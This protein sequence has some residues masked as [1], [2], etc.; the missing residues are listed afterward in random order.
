M[1]TQNFAGKYV[2]ISGIAGG[3]EVF[4]GKAIDEPFADQLMVEGKALTVSP[5]GYMTAKPFVTMCHFP[6]RDANCQIQQITTPEVLAECDRIHSMPVVHLN[7]SVYPMIYHWI[8][9][10]I[11]REAFPAWTQNGLTNQRNGNMPSNPFSVF[12]DGF[13][14]TAEQFHR[15][16]FQSPQVS[17]SR[18]LDRLSELKGDFIIEV[19]KAT[20]Q[21]AVKFNQAI[22]G[23]PELIRHLELIEG[24]F[25]NVPPTNM[26]ASWT[27][28]IQRFEIAKNW[29]RRNNQPQLIR[30]INVLA[31][32]GITRVNEII[33]DRCT[34]LDTLIAEACSQYGISHETIGEMSP[35]ASFNAPYHKPAETIEAAPAMAGGGL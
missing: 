5:Q 9:S 2:L 18:E 19:G 27:Y 33:L 32:E 34:A 21:I 20:N 29:A 10:S 31:K 14:N 4:L 35:F 26:L 23:A 25:T 17:N 12:Q 7:R 28:L 6:M 8:D 13:F 22:S 24:S 30:E 1:T 15:A 16:L 11:R 3:R